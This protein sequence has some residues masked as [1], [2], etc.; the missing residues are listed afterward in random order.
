MSLM[1]SNLK[2]SHSIPTKL[3]QNI[4]WC[5]LK[6]RIKLILRVGTCG[7]ALAPD[8]VQRCTP[9]VTVHCTAK[10]I[11]PTTDRCTQFSVHRWYIEGHSTVY[12]LPSR[13]VVQNF[14]YI[15]GISQVTVH[16]TAE[17]ILPSRNDVHH[18]LYIYGTS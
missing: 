7:Q 17:Y 14:L 5:P 4:L 9:L 8:H 3:F 13:T 10:Y 15:E 16:C 2:P 18:F 6:L 11:F 12:I 1:I